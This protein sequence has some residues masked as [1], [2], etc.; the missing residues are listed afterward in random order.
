[1]IIETESA[2]NTSRV[3]I[4]D[5][6][7]CHARPKESLIKFKSIYTTCRLVMFYAKLK[8]KMIVNNAGDID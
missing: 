3:L 6:F 7:K 1:M 5:K 8:N 2:Q 4:Q